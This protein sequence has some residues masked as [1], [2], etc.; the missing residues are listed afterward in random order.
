MSDGAHLE[1]LA[2]ASS[3]TVG[4]CPVTYGSGRSAG[5]SKPSR[6][7][8]S[9][10]PSS[11]MS[12]V[13]DERR[14]A[15]LARLGDVVERALP[16]AQDVELEPARRGAAAAAISS[17]ALVVIV[18]THMSVPAAARGARGRD[19]A[20]RVEQPLH[21]ERRDERAASRRAS[22]ARVVAVETSADVD[23]HPRPEAP[24]RR[25][26][27]RSPGASPRRPRRPRS[28][29]RPSG[30]PSRLRARSSRRR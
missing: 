11:G 13:S 1:L 20:L 3:A 17:C 23:E 21:R 18:E 7:S 25:R 9:R 2:R 15:G 6:R 28:S 16:V 8:R 5:T 12:T 29:T 24:A 14:V 27:R 10:R 30:R 22:R 26:R 19:L 4:S